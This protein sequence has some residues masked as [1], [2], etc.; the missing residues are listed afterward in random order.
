MMTPTGTD[1]LLVRELELRF[2]KGRRTRSRR[3]HGGWFRP[4]SLHLVDVV[5]GRFHISHPGSRSPILEQGEAILITPGTRYHICVADP[6]EAIIRYAH[7]RL[8]LFGSVDICGLC[9]LPAI[10][11]APQG[12]RLGDAIQAVA[13]SRAA[14][15]A[16]DIASVGA[17]HRAQAELAG[18]ILRHARL[19]EHGRR[20]LAGALRLLPVLHY[21]RAHLTEPVQRADL[22]LVAGLSPSRLSAV[23]KQHF[24]QAPMQFLRQQ[25]LER[26]RAR[27]VFEGASVTEVADQ[28]CF[29]DPFHF[30]KSFKQAFGVSPSRCREAL[31]GAGQ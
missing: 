30:S 17:C 4:H 12:K 24:G 10:L 21:I 31:D 20:V 18:E 1:D 6:D 13:S 8:S 27:L 2:Y 15:V 11:P 28:Y 22:A 16:A 23:F 9:S 26:A 25:R 5:R 19:T 3:E 7:V 29:T 14:L